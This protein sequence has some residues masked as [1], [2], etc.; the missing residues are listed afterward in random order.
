MDKLRLTYLYQQ[1]Q[2]GRL[3]PAESQEWEAAVSDL[4]HDEAL[5]DLVEAGW[6]L[7]HSP[8]DG[9]S[10]AEQESMYEYIVG[11]PQESKQV[12]TVPLWRQV[13]VISALAAAVAVI[14]LGVW[15][16]GDVI[17]MLRQAQQKDNHQAQTYINDITPGKNTATL[18]LANGETINLSDTKTG[19]IIEA[20]SFTY[21]DGSKIDDSSLRGTDPSSSRELRSKPISSTLTAS[22]PRG[23]TYQVTLPDGT[24]VWLNAD[25]KIT[26][27]SQFS[28]KTRA[29]QLTGEAYLEVAKDKAHPFI[30]ESKGQKVTVLGTHFNINAYN[31]ESEIKTTL[32]EG[33]VEV[34][35]AGVSSGMRYRLKPGQQSLNNGATIQVSQAKV[36]EVTAWKNGDFQFNE[37]KL[38][39]IMKKLE[40]WY[41]VEIV[42]SDKLA[43]VTVTGNI[44]RNRNISRVL[45]MMEKTNRIHFKIEGRR[46]IAIEK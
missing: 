30:V 28:G 25:S 44:A 24:A 19:V 35:A 9:L 29:I 31:D 27:P 42:L 14:T 12:S 18:T 23:G 21:N 43:D 15:L 41:D 37:E 8:A 45:S 22:T 5:L 32:L 40:R 10:A 1:Y 38:S 7:D 2:S 3:T 33:S 16:Y 4:R 20:S 11:Q 26:F 36:A 39:S 6:K 17:L 34:S 13:K 46:I